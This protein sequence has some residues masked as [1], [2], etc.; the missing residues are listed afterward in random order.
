MITTDTWLQEFSDYNNIYNINESGHQEINI[1]KPLATKKIRLLLNNLYDDVPLKF[2]RLA[3]HKKGQSDIVVHI[4]G[5]D[6]FE[7]ARKVKEMH[8]YTCSDIVKVLA[9]CTR[10]YKRSKKE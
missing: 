10:L 3:L 2:T 7:I 6:S 5:K 4:D 1:F 9:I 8:C